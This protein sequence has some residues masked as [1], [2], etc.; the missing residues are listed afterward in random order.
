MFPADEDGHGG[1]R[2]RRGQGLL[3]ADGG[4]TAHAGAQGGGQRFDRLEAAGAGPG[5]SAG[6]EGR[7]RGRAASRL[8]RAGRAPCSSS[9]RRRSR[10]ASNPGS[11][12]PSAS[13]PVSPACS[14]FA[15]R[16]TMIRAS[17]GPGSGPSAEAAVGPSAEQPAIA[18]GARATAVRRVRRGAPDP[19]KASGMGPT[20]SHVP[21]TGGARR[22]GP[23]PRA[24]G[25]PIEPADRPRLLERG[26]GTGKYA[27]RSVTGWR[28]CAG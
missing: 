3:G 14:F 23:P 22:S 1:R 8:K 27:S 12:V 25:R 4:L 16:I 20:V 10:P 6:R 28:G 2:A 21:D 19:A 15:G 17:F 9:A 26:G 7:P 18:S 5:R 24:P 13:S 11:S